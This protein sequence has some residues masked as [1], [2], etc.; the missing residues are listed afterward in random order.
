V[1]NKDD[2]KEKLDTYF[3]N[4][5]RYVKYSKIDTCVAFSFFIKDEVAFRSFIQRF[6]VSCER[7]D[8]VLG[9]EINL[10]IDNLDSLESFDENKDQYG[11]EM[12]SINENI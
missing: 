10:Q 2:L 3:C 12:I 11:F 8:S 7:K 1:Q 5:M 6:K 4:Q 9:L